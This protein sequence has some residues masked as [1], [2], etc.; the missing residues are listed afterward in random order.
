[1]RAVWSFV[2]VRKFRA[3]WAMRSSGVSMMSFATAEKRARITK[4]SGR[5]IIIVVAVAFSC[6]MGFLS[7]RP[8]GFGAVVLWWAL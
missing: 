4:I 6:F 3:L 7:E 8:R 5:A 1:M 2:W